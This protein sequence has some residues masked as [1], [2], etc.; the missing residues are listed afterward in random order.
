MS[1]WDHCACA[2][3]LVYRAPQPASPTPSAT[4]T[5]ADEPLLQPMAPPLRP[6]SD[7][8]HYESA[9]DAPEC[10]VVVAPS[11]VHMQQRRLTIGRLKSCDV[12][13]DGTKRPMLISRLH[14]ELL[15]PSNSISIAVGTG[16]SGSNGSV[17]TATSGSGDDHGV[18]NIG[19]RGSDLADM[20]AAKTA[21]EWSIVDKGSL[22]GVFV[23]S[24]KISA[25]Q[26]VV[27]HH[28]D[29]IVFGGGGNVLPGSVV[30]QPESE[31]QFLF[32]QR[33]GRS[34]EPKQTPKQTSLDPSS[35]IVPL[36]HQSS[37][38][39][40]TSEQFKPLP[41]PGTSGS[42]LHLTPNSTFQPGTSDNIIPHTQ[43]G[44]TNT[45]AQTTSTSASEESHTKLLS[46]SESCIIQNP[47]S[48]VSV[49]TTTCLNIQ[50]PIPTNFDQEPHELDC[51]SSTISPSPK[52]AKVEVTVSTT[53][54]SPLSH[55]KNTAFPSQLS[56]IKKQV[57]ILEGNK[58]LVEESE[59]KYKEVEKTGKPDETA[60][61]EMS[62]VVAATSTTEAG[63]EEDRAS[64]ASEELLLL[65]KTIAEDYIPRS[66]LES[67][68]TCSVCRDLFIDPCTLECSHSF[69][70][71]CIEHW[72]QQQSDCPLCRTKVR[73]TAVQSLTLRN[74]VSALIKGLSENQITHYQA[75]L[76][77]REDS[78]THSAT[79]LEED[80][81]Y[82]QLKKHIS[83]AKERGLPFLKITD[84]WTKTDQKKFSSGIGRY[85]TGPCRELY[86][87]TTGLTP[88][89]VRSTS[90]AATLQCALVNVGLV[91][92]R[93]PLPQASGVPVMRRM[94]MDFIQGH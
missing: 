12:R 79:S 23:N 84:T 72:L 40:I 18:G 22:N 21:V 52:R 44:G 86:A 15:C 50:Q 65:H 74:A 39:F 89:W 33:N 91:P 10:G 82:K 11:V 38:F 59:A 46:V 87:E 85:P 25:G 51:V 7:A 90:S 2:S 8:A 41:R 69:C 5:A 53:S 29:L 20:V 63:P 60:K 62:L 81:K 17:S 94:L 14:A 32:M 77:A 83:D 70:A 76:Q 48:T 30:H 24:T 43:N 92:S 3:H 19:G 31:F 45:T 58:K 42:S 78:K 71:E 93:A 36:S 34:I 57:A 49:S 28:R 88:A 37:H 55:C 56:E 9:S 64:R 27:L 1:H 67:E 61:E 47:T 80:P 4:A 35:Q 66:T 75:R 6:P 13:L 16:T 26:P 73:K 54:I 68:F